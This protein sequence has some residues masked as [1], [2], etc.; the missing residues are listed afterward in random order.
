M[1]NRSE[2]IYQRKF[3]SAEGDA[4]LGAY[5]Q[6]TLCGSGGLINKNTEWLQHPSTWIVYVV[7]CGIM[8]LVLHLTQLFTVQESTTLLNVIHGMVTFVFFHW[9]KGTP[10]EFTQGDW[11]GLTLW[12][13]L[14]AGLPWTSTKKF[15]IIV[16]AVLLF[17]ALACSD[18]KPFYVI[19]NLPVFILLEI[20]KMPAMHRVRILSIN[21]TAG[22]DD[23][24][25][26]RA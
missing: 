16:P 25:K 14:D 26:K 8:F 6:D 11:N 13:Q 4:Y 7:F 5:S 18:Y 22:I 24:P 15:L 2:E 10:D 23:T 17:V 9:I 12:E 20:A 19:I 3:S 21:S 1:S